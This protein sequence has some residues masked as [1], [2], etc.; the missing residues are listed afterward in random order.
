MF[1]IG[2]LQKLILM[3]LFEA[4]TYEMYQSKLLSTKGTMTNA[5]T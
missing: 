1:L 4:N 2:F 5:P 3:K